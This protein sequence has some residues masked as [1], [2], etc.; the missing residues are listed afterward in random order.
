M[1]NLNSLRKNLNL[2]KNFNTKCMC[3]IK[4]NKFI[5]NIS[6]KNNNNNNNKI[7]MM[8]MIIL[9]LIIIIKIIIII[10]ICH[11]N[12]IITCFSIRRL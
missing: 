12:Y 11:D 9:L 8:I 10:I 7:K 4:I 5:N 1:Q 2:E 3:F 6:N